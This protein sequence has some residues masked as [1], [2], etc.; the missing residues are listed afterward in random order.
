MKTTHSFFRLF[1]FFLFSASLSH[2]QEINLG[3]SAVGS[4]GALD[5]WS[6]NMVIREEAI[7]VN[8]TPDEVTL[9]G[10]TFEFGVGNPRSRVTPFLV[11]LND[12]N[13][14]GNFTDDNDFEVL[15]IGTTRVSGIDFNAAGVVSFPFNESNES[16][17]LPAGTALGAAYMDS[18]P[19]GTG[20]EGGSVIPFDGNVPAGEM[21]YAG[22]SGPTHP[23]PIEVGT[24]L[25]GL[26]A[27]GVENRN[28]QFSIKVIIGELEDADGDGIPG[29]IEALYD[30]LSDSNPADAELDQDSDDSSNLEE[31]TLGTDLEDPDTDDDEILDG[32]ESNTGI[33]VSETDTGTD[34][35]NADSDGDSLPDGVET[36]DGN[37]VDLDQ[38]GTDPNKED[39]DDDDW[40]D[41][42]EISFGSDAQDGNS[43]PDL[44]LLGTD[45]LPATGGVVDGWRSNLIVDEGRGYT[46]ETG[47]TQVI[48]PTH[49]R[50]RVGNVRSRVTP[51]IVKINDLNGD[52]N[53]YDDNDFTV[54][55][56]GTTR[57]AN[58][59]YT[60]TGRWLFT[61]D[62]VGAEFEL[63]DGER[64]A[65]AFIDADPDGLNGGE[66]SVIPYTGG[67][68]PGEM[69]YNGT[70]GEPHPSPPTPLD[71]GG[72]LTGPPAAGVEDRDYFFQ[73]GY[74]I[75]GSLSGLTITSIFYLD[76]AVTLTWDSK[77]NRVYAVE[78][79]TDL[80]TSWIEQN[81]SWNSQGDSTTF[82][83]PANPGFGFPDFSLIPSAL[84][85]VRDV[86]P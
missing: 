9:T 22:N 49:F 32:H 71:L 70:G 41:R 40:G 65:P 12:T 30:F 50:F 59:D 77:P 21:W 63:A 83:F 79:L 57:I 51:L 39:S 72:N 82:T 56:I 2:G 25:S 62:E 73:I 27:A 20:G 37:F 47:S 28:Y 58:D 19:N 75:G 35:R 54:M 44:I 14:N 36:N 45:D 29:S 78:Y 7:Y 46:N 67:V 18:N 6:S 43:F 42:E 10:T 17:A 13:S 4:T 31:F 60:A 8:D 48:R 69:W 26:P 81:D 68:T 38:T 84:F 80:E 15:A 33:W 11:Q 34:P 3:S 64:I 76:G 86:T 5:G 16:F 24:L 61:F 55:A 53:F 1:S 23:N 66:G 52:G 74:E 85:R